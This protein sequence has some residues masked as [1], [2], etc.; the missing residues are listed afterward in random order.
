MKPKPQK[1]A[2][3]TPVSIRINPD[4]RAL[5]DY[6]IERTGLKDAQI[7]RLAIKRLSELE[8]QNL[9]SVKSATR[10]K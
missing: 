10:A 3:S 4:T 5:L 9:R 6:L 8:A 1:P 2:T 7:I